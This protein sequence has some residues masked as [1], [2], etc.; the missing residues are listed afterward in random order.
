VALPPVPL[1]VSVK[2]VF[3]AK[4]G[5][6][7]LPLVALLPVQPLEAV[8]AVA[9]VELQVSVDAPPLATLVGLALSV[10]VGAGVVVTVTA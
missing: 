8:Q 10:I 3:A 2:I 9:L 4:A 1:H 7:S 5:V 6:V